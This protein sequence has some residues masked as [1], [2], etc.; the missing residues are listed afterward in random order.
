MKLQSSG[1]G[2]NLPSEVVSR[3]R[4]ARN[5][6][7]RSEVGGG[8]NLLIVAG[9]GVSFVGFAEASSLFLLENEGA[10]AGEA[11]NR[12]SVSEAGMRGKSAV[13][14]MKRSSGCEVGGGAWIITEVWATVH[15]GVGSS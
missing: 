6:S 2:F 11:E 13:E 14:K 7:G 3:T 1:S 9:S 15:Y 5:C 12:V 4:V 8:L 10:S